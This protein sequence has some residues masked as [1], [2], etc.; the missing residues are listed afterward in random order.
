MVI[1]NRSKRE[2]LS[3]YPRNE[4][5]K[6][7][8]KNVINLGGQEDRITFD[9][10]IKKVPEK[11]YEKSGEKTSER[12]GE[13]HSSGKQVNISF[14]FNPM[15]I[16][17]F[18][19][20]FVLLVASFFLGK[21]TTGTLFG[22][23]ESVSGLAIVEPGV[24]EVNTNTETNSAAAEETIVEEEA[25]VNETVEET[26]EVVEEVKEEELITT[27]SKVALS[28]DEIESELKSAAD[29]KPR[30]G[31]INKIKYTI[32]NSENGKIMPKYLVIMTPANRDYE[33]DVKVSEEAEE[34]FSTEIVSEWGELERPFSFNEKTV[35]NL[36]K[37]KLILTLYDYN[38][39]IMTTFSGTFDLSK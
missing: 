8:P 7:A 25:P 15:K 13:K 10:A 21:Y 18:S 17:K 2:E 5:P 1:V 22:D 27:Y 32:K 36:E 30:W 26:V 3:N 11:N 4:M 14:D 9:P 35:G 19:F 38:D 6:E 39:K 23:E 16:L 34:L 29:E 33:K 31:V 20:L 28:L 24:V 12:S 37:V